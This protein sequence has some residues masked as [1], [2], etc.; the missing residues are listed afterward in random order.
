MPI[1]PVETI[2]ETLLAGYDAEHME[3]LYRQQCYAFGEPWRT[4]D[5]GSRGGLLVDFPDITADFLKIGQSRRILNAQFVGLSRVMYSTPAPEFPHLDK[6]SAETL[7]QFLLARSGEPG[8]SDGEACTEDESVFLDGDGLGFGCAQIVLSTNPETGFQRVGVRHIPATQVILDRHERNP[9]KARWVA[10]VHHL[11]PDVAEDL[12]GE[13]VFEK[14][15]TKSVDGV[16]TDGLTTMRVVEYYDLG[17]GGGEPARTV[18][19]GDLNGEVLEHEANEC[20]CLPFAHYIHFVPPGGKKP[21]GRIALQMAT[22]EAINEVEAYMRRQM[23]KPGVDLVDVNQVDPADA[24]RLMAGN[25]D[26]P[27]RYTPQANS[28]APITRTPGA[29]V[30]VSTLNWHGMLDRQFASDSG[31]SEF[32]RGNLSSEQRTL[33]ENQLLDQRS[34]V[35]GMWSRMQASRYHRRKFRVMLEMAKRFDRDPVELDIFGVNVPVN[36]PA[37]PESHISEF[38]RE[39]SAIVVNEDSLEYSDLKAQRAQKIAEL[40]AM[41]PLV[42]Q[43]LVDAV[44]WAEEMVKGLGYEPKEAMKT[45]LMAQ[46]AGP[47]M[48]G[49]M[50]GGTDP[51]TGAAAGLQ[52]PA[53]AGPALPAP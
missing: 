39:R 9:S 23:R 49:A 31:T 12:Y 21:I 15:R 16:D 25:Y 47:Q 1:T 34:Q 33:G 13:K 7:K 42:A 53:P 41:Q 51:A 14:F 46:Q 6:Y 52:S 40:N 3:R 44:W 35:Q 24:K 4:G 18:L 32:E 30:P 26:K 29:E 27:L 37:V 11:A 5:V 19:A 17:L 50:P 20:G 38:C 36:D 8:A 45:A 48:P 28:G 2:K 22:Q 10:F 43:G